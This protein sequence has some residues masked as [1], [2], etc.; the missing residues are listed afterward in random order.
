MGPW[1][2]PGPAPLSRGKWA[3]P[4]R[5][6]AA[7]RGRLTRRSMT[8]PVQLAL[9]VTPLAVYLYLLA[10]WQAGRHPRVVSGRLDVWLLALG[11][12]GLALLGPLGQWLLGLLSKNPGSLHRL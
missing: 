12:G 8:S 3:D 1:R 6:G 5:A 10:V 2:C 11:L 4:H 7:P 9:M